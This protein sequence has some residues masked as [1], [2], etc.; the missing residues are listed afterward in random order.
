MSFWPCGAE[1][2]R[3][4]VNAQ[5][6]ADQVLVHQEACRHLDRTLR[7]IQGEGV[8]AGV[9]INPSTP[10]GSLENILEVADYVLVMAYPEGATS[11][12]AG[13]MA[14]IPP[15][16]AGRRVDA[17]RAVAPGTAPLGRRRDSHRRPLT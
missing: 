8:K 16:T 5:A 2:A 17:G 3:A 6:G 13:V 9:V 1:L 12:H 4:R 10:V 7:M 11:P 15:D 14:M